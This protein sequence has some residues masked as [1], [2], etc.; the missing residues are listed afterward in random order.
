MSLDQKNRK[1]AIAMLLITYGVLVVI[2]ALWYSL[3]SG[4]WTSFHR[5]PL[6]L[7]GMAFLSLGVIKGYTWATRVA[8]GI[9]AIFL[10]FGSLGFVMLII[11][12]MFE[13]SLL[14]I[15]PLLIVLGVAFKL[16]RDEVKSIDGTKAHSLQSK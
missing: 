2:G 1:K 15:I 5:A 7:V 9:V 12:R 11:T 14:G 3:S 4:D 10:V 16:L 6:R 8:F 13:P